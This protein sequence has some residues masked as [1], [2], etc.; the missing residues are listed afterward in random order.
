LDRRME[1]SGNRM[2]FEN[3]SGSPASGTSLI[4]RGFAT[5]SSPSGE[6]RGGGRLIRME[7]IVDAQNMA[8][9]LNQ[10]GSIGDFIAGESFSTFQ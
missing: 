8:H 1:S 9:C 5:N 10:K 7:F 4:R 2:T 3:L 6:K